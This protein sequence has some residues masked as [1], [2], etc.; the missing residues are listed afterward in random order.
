M[1]AADVGHRHRQD[2]LALGVAGQHHVGRRPEPPIRHLHHPRLR[3][4]RR[5]P[6]R[7][8]LVVVLRRL[9]RLALRALLARR[10]LRH[11]RQRRLKLLQLLLGSPLL[12]RAPTATAQAPIAGGFR[13]DRRQLL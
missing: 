7:R 9:A 10:D 5:H 1:V 6:W 2:H 3:I 8:P 11:L 4:R 13:L 12:G